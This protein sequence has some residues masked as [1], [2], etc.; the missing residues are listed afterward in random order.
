MKSPPFEITQKMLID[1]A[2]ISELVGRLSTSRLSSSPI[3]RRTNRIRLHWANCLT[4]KMPIQRS[5]ICGTLNCAINNT[6]VYIL[7]D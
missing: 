1:T 3:L 7:E 5:K 6:T 2:E 4:E